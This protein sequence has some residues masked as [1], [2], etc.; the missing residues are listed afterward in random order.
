[1]ELA[2]MRSPHIATR[3]RP[4]TRTRATTRVCCKSLMSICRSR[5]WPGDSSVC[6]CCGSSD[7]LRTKRWTAFWPP[8]SRSAPR[9]SKARRT[10]RT[11]GA[12]NGAIKL[13]Y[14]RCEN[15]P[16]SRTPRGKQQCPAETKV[17][18]GI[19]HFAFFILHLSVPLAEQPRQRSAK[20]FRWVQLPH[21]TPTFAQH[22]EEKVSLRSL[23]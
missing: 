4:L 13:A 11:K 1:M 22:R 20:P 21:G 9:Q 5:K 17:S 14:A 12:L 3:I 6:Q 15:N 10:Q 16:G 19:L 18:A 2:E 23:V 7:S 8:C